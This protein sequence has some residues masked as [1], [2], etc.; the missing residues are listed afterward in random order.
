[1]SGDEKKLIR[2]MDLPIYEPFHKVEVIEKKVEE[3]G[4]AQETVKTVRTTIQSFIGQIIN[5]KEQAVDVIEIGK[6][7][8]EGNNV[9]FK[10]CFHGILNLPLNILHNSYN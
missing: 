2:P 6:A 1:M 9:Y 7:H 4:I 3:P 8:T 10:S 5:V